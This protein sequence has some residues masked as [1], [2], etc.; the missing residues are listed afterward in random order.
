MS[1]AIV[2]KPNGGNDLAWILLAVFAVWALWLMGVG[3]QQLGA[4]VGA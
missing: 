2:Q 4:L 3:I 1:H